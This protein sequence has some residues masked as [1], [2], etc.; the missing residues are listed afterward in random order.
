MQPV[1]W[2]EAR[3]AEHWLRVLSLAL[4]VYGDGVLRV[5]HAGDAG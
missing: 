1:P 3:L 5:W 4:H 2:R